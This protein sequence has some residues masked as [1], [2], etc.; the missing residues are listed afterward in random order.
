MD[1]NGPCN[2][3]DFRA[4]LADYRRAYPDD[5]LTFEDA[6]SSDQDVTAVIWR[7]NAE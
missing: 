4:F 5:V 3:Q 1:H 2:H 7:L 6:V